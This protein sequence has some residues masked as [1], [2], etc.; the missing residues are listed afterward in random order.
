MVDESRDAITSEIF[1]DTII[2]ADAPQLEVLPPEEADEPSKDETLSQEAERILWKGITMRDRVW[3]LHV[4]EGWSI[5][6]IARSQGRTYQAIW[7]HWKN[8]EAEL[9]AAPPDNEAPKRRA[10]LR[11]R[12]EAQYTRAMRIK[13]TER[14]IVLALKTLEVMARLDGLN[15]EAKDDSQKLV[16]Y[17]PPEQ[18]AEDVRAVVLKRWNRPA[19]I[20]PAT[21]D[22][23]LTP[24]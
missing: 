24:E 10:L 12:L 13:D 18:V 1:L 4:Q 23:G 16:P 9:E 5:M 14:S 6:D 11:E 8:I 2:M 17:V 22:D 19:L 7:L 20:H 15:L 3:V 21:A